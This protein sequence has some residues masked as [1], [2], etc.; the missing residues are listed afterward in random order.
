VPAKPITDGSIGGHGL[1]L[2]VDWHRFAGQRRLVDTQVARLQQ[3]YVRRQ[4]VA[5]SQQ[6][7]IPGHQ[8]GGI[9]V[10]LA[11]IAQH[12]R[13]RRQQMPN[14]L[15]RFFRL[16]LLNEADHHVDHHH[17]Q[18][19]EGVDQM[20]H[21]AGYQRRGDQHIKQKIVEMTQ[22]ALPDTRRLGLI[23]PI[24]TVLQQALPGLFVAEAG[25]RGL[26]FEQRLIALPSMPAVR[27]CLRVGHW[28][29]LISIR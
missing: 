14:R 2:L 20:P 26:Q 23:E 11:A 13:V 17:R 27:L 16:A 15:Q 8:L 6:Y 18:D 29:P 22:Q 10:L 1:D 24:G 5:G 7:H 12:H 28:I 25:T 21:Q 9:E 3:P 19:H 4:A